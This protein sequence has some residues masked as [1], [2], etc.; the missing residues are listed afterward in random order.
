MT[1]TDF[2]KFCSIHA[3]STANGHLLE[4]GLLFNGAGLS[5]EIDMGTGMLKL[6]T[7]TLHRYGN[8]SKAIFNI[9]K[10]QF[11]QWSGDGTLDLQK[12][13]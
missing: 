12:R 3:D 10:H 6:N 7:D 8:S 13:F 11:P 4:N 2:D 9:F 1:I 5:P